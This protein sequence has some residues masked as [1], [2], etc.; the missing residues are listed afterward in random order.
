VLKRAPTMFFLRDSTFWLC[1]MLRE[2]LCVPVN[3]VVGLSNSF[4]FRKWLKS[5]V[6][7]VVRTLRVYERI[8][9]QPNALITWRE[10]G[11]PEGLCGV[12]GDLIPWVVQVVGNK[13]GT[14]VLELLGV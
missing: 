2:R 10:V 12:K 14:W 1:F 8:Y 4:L 11:R 13:F 5:L 7:N 9:G 3:Q 6:K